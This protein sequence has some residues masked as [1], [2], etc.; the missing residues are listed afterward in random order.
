MLLEAGDRIP[1]DC[2][3]LEE[4]DMHVDQAHYFPEVAELAEKQCSRDEDQ[5]LENPDPILLTG[6]SIMSGSGKA[7]LAVGKHTL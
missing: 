4:M 3:L 5:H 6:C 7:V 1:A 2:L